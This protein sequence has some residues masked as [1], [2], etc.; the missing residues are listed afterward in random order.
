MEFGNFEKVVEKPEIRQIA[1]SILK[2]PIRS[3][4]QICERWGE[5][6]EEVREY[7]AYV[8]TSGC[9]KAILKKTE[10]IEADIYKEYLSKGEFNVPHLFGTV[11]KE[12]ETWICIQCIEGN[13]LRDMT[14]GK[15]LSAAKTLSAVQMYFWTDRLECSPENT[16]ENRFV[17]Y[18]RR[19]L[20]RA[21]FV[22]DKPVLRKAYQIFLDRQLTCPCTLS[23]GDF[24]EYNAVFDGKKVVMIDWGFGGM[25]P[26][27]L[28]IARFIAHATET[29]S[30]FPFYMTDAQKELFL[31]E[32]YEHLKEKITYEQYRFDVKLA[33][34]NEYVEFVEADEDVDNWYITHAEKIALEIC[35]DEENIRA[36]E[37]IF[38]ANAGCEK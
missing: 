30:T 4:A 22:A 13:D 19:V 5:K 8:I 32:I 34:L 12:N 7:D 17:T 25:M 27:S 2:E 14:D 18:W 23:S 16:V 10:K 38:A 28:D 31:N 36:T 35:K 9:K 20:R 29:R 33:L 26:Y 1:E 6:E 11:Q 21:S 24:L 3:A 37:N 15:A